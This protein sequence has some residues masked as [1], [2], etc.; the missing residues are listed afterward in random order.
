MTTPVPVVPKHK[1]LGMSAVLLP[2]N[3]D[4]SIDWPG[5]EAHVARTVE[6]GLVPAVNMD[7]GYA[8][9]LDDATRIEALQR[10]RDTCRGAR[11]VAGAGVFDGPDDDFNP[12][13]YQTAIDEVQSHKGEPVVFQ[14]FGL[15]KLDDMLLAPA[16][17]QL[18]KDADT[19]IAFELGQMFA[20]F[21]KIY[22]LDAYQALM[23]LPNCIGAKHS[24]LSRQLEWDRLALRNKVRPDFHVFTGNDLA[25]DMIM[26]GSD[27]LLGLS[28]L[29]PDLFAKRDQLWADGDAAFYQVNDLLQYLGFFAFRDPVPAY[30]HDAAMFL[31]LRGWI[32]CD[33][34]HPQSTKRPD[35]DREV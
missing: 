17:A 5:F 9:L 22:S 19:F 3:P 35:A 30:K 13:A 12:G 10:T 21:G 23:K 28:T 18:S 20:T 4:G 26:Y 2:F 7:T 29:A 14:S 11:Y 1:P 16:Y 6:A 25:I 31:K 27:Y 32:G 24:S 33:D 34:T 15:T 8:P